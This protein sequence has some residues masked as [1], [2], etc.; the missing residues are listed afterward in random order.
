MSESRILQ[1]RSIGGL[2]IH[3]A[4]RLQSEQSFGLEKQKGGISAIY[5]T[6]PLRRVTETFRF[7]ER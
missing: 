6:R 1:L 4:A 2:E 3:D 5:F 7:L